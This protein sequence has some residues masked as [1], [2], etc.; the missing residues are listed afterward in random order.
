LGGATTGDHGQFVV[1]DD[2]QNV[3]SLL[4]LERQLDLYVIVKDREDSV[5]HEGLYEF[6]EEMRR[7]AYPPLSFH[8]KLDEKTQGSRPLGDLSEE[9]PE[10]RWL[11]FFRRGF[12][13]LRRR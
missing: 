9:S 4:K 13:W 1:G 5:L 8:I 10:T 12:R 7:D 11:L 2:Q 3:A 6:P